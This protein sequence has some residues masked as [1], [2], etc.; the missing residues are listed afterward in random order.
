MTVAGS[1]GSEQPSSSRSEVR[2]VTTARCFPGVAR[3]RQLFLA[4]GKICGKTLPQM[5]NMAAHIRRAIVLPL[6]IAAL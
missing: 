3:M 4:N 6:M 1:D 5:Q 2:S